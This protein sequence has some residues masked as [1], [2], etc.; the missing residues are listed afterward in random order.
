[1]MLGRTYFAVGQPQRALDA[2]EKAYG[3]EP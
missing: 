3:L 1:M 2:L